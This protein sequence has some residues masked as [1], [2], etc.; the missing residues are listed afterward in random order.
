MNN[1]YY[2]GY[3]KFN[4]KNDGGEVLK[5]YLLDYSTKNIHSIYKVS[6]KDM[7]SKLDTKYKIF[8]NIT[9]DIT[10]AIKRNGQ[11]SLDIK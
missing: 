2:I 3:E 7:C 9:N 10:Y 8:D 1:I 5:I 4:S 6:S 11:I